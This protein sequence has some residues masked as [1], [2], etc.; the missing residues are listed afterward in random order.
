MAA[1]ARWTKSGA[2]AHASQGDRHPP[3]NGGV[4]LCGRR[5]G[6]AH[7][8]DRGTA[9]R[10]AGAAHRAG[11]VGR[12]RA[13]CRGRARD[14]A[15]GRA[16]RAAARAALESNVRRDV[17]HCSICR[18]GRR[19]LDNER[20]RSKEVFKVAVRDTTESGLLL[21]STVRGLV[22]LPRYVLMKEH[23]D[24]RVC[25]FKGRGKHRRRGRRQRGTRG[26]S[27]RIPRAAGC[28]SPSGGV[29]LALQE[30]V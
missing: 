6:G 14:G 3:R 28:A 30:D 27:S 15:H 22:G 23:A 29:R 11:T 1:R 4:R 18:W 26:L 8:P 24:Q 16:R 10:P 5:R 21:H 9:P 25:V 19:E 7:H 13:A 12:A 20:P 17:G 2:P